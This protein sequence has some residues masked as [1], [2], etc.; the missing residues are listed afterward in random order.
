[1]S[2]AA[3]KDALA[4]LGIGWSI[5]E[6]EAVYTVEESLA[7]HDALPGAHTKNL[8]LKDAGGQFWLVTVEHMRRVD[9]KALAGVIGAKKLSFGKA[10]DMERLLGVTPGS[11]TPLAAL[12]D[13]GGAVRVVLD[14]ELAAVDIVNV[15]PLRNTA[16][17]G[18]SGADL[19]RA[20]GAWGHDPLIAA[21]PE[22]T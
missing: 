16:T 7:I 14:S 15:H 8:F 20:L 10:E 3:L 4:A 1:M 19:V 17:V 2:D 6:H 12:N 18:L 13:T 21:I 9:L 22:R 11:V 5:L